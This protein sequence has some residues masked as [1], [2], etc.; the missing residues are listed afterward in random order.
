MKV[1]LAQLDGKLP[2]LALMRISAHHRQRGDACE[3]RFGAQF[4]RAL[5]DDFGTVYGSAIFVKT[6]PLAKRLR[7]VYP[8]AIIGGTGYDTD[9]QSR[10]SASRP[11]LS[12]T[13]CTRLSASRLASPNEVADSTVRSVSCRKKKVA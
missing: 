6:L 2:N 11:T 3:V 5:W 7:V 4:E 13:R 9:P 8:Q 12:I 10:P 1:L